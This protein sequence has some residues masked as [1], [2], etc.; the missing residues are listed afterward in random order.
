MKMI[1]TEVSVRDPFVLVYDKKY[2]L[3]GTRVDTCWGYADGF[4]VQVSNDLINWSEKKEVFHNDGSFWAD[5]NYW[6]PEVHVYKHKFYMMVSFKKEGLARGT[7]ILKADSPMGPFTPISEG[8]VTPK[9][10]ECLDGTLF[11]NRDNVPYIVFCHEWKQIGNGTIC[12]MELSE[13][14]THTVSDPILLFD[15]KGTGWTRCVEGP[16]CYVTDGPF[17]WWMKDGSLGMLWSSHGEAG[18][19]QAVAKSI[20]GTIEGPWTQQEELLFEKDGG[21]GMLFE[22]LEGQT[23]LALHAPNDTPNEKAVF[24]PVEEKEGMMVLKQS[25]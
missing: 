3:Y 22:T 12:A 21:H 6:A 19:G 17:M 1:K 13:D 2:Y 9:D 23:M 11:L 7:Q 8:P 4:D 10:W 20:N 5:Q 15:A 14:L 25:M 24:F 16:D 18:Y